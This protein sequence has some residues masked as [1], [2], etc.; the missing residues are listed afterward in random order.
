VKFWGVLTAK[1]G[2]FNSKDNFVILGV[3]TTKIDPVRGGGGEGV[4]LIAI[5]N[6]WVQIERFQSSKG[7]VKSRSSS[8]V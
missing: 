2:R 8:G 5:E 7:Y 4:K 1:I 3:L 6:S